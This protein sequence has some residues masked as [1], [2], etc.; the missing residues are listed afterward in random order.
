[1][2]RLFSETQDLSK[3]NVFV[4]FLFIKLFIYTMMQRQYDSV[5]VTLWWWCISQTYL[6]IESP[7]SN[8]WKYMEHSLRRAS[9]TP[10]I[11][12]SSSFI[13]GLSDLAVAVA[14]AVRVG[15]LQS[16]GP[17]QYTAC[18]CIFFFFFNVIQTCLLVYSLFMAA[19]AMPQQN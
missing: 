1:M 9:L 14:V 17:I 13:G 8:H 6:I 7:W 5:T 4:C 3:L 18:L 15:K 11:L 2:S 19:F 16:T 12:K 10:D